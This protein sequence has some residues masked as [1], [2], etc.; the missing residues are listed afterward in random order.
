MTNMGSG[1]V[2]GS[3]RVVH[4]PGPPT[5]PPRVHLLLLPPSVP[6]CHRGQHPGV[7]GAVGLISV[8]QLSLYVHISDIRAFTE[9]YN[10]VRIDNPNDHY[11]ILGNE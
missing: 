8:A 6:P 9:V 1:R 7:K 11:F 10:L 5:S 3:T 2:L 4:P